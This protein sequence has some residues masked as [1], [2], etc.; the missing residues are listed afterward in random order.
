MPAPIDFS[1]WIPPEFSTQIIQEAIQASAV[2]TLGN[3]V[4]MGTKITQMPVPKVFPKAAFTS[5]GGARKPFTD[6]KVGVETMTA[7]ELAAVV[8]IPDEYIEDSAINLWNFTRPLLAQALALALDQAVLWGIDAPATYPPGGVAAAALEAPEGSDVVET[9]NQA[10]GQVETQGLAV[11]GHAADL[12]VKASL[13]GVRD[14]S[15]ALLLG[16]NQASGDATG[17]LYGL[18][19]SWQ[20]FIGDTFDFITGAWQYLIIGVR[21]DIRFDINPAGVIA[22]DSGAVIVS[23]WQDN[24]TPL[25]VWARFA[26]ALVKPVTPREPDGAVPFSVAELAPGGAGNGGDDDNGDEPAK[27]VAAPVKAAAKKV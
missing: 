1:G 23:G 27:K 20:S 8:A 22:D 12:A 25:K 5:G 11:T 17:T 6:L 7:E 9:I 18:P 21:Q 10:M 24:T 13:R 19:I 14:G 3:R 15:N 26:V 4:P 16:P 2:L